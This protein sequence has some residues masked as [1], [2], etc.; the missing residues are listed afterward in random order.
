MG[1]YRPRITLNL[2]ASTFSDVMAGFEPYGDVRFIA[3]G[4]GPDWFGRGYTGHA[5]AI[6]LDPVT[7]PGVVWVESDLWYPTAELRLR[8]VGVSPADIANQAAAFMDGY[9]YE[10]T[11]V[12]ADL[13]DSASDLSPARYS[14]RV[15]ITPHGRVT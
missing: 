10:V 14:G 13:T 12:N 9:R 11:D 7:P 8:P 15:V 4:F 3:G 6:L 2:S 1:L 5:T